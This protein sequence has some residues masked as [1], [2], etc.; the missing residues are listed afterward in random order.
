MADRG[1]W[2]LLTGA[3]AG[4]I[5]VIRIVGPGVAEFLARHFARPAK[6]GRCVHGEL[7]DRAG[8]VLDDIVVV[9]VGD[10]QTADLNLHGGP[11]VVE[12]VQNLLRESGFVAGDALDGFESSDIIEREMLAALP[13]AKTEAGIRML[14][15]QPE[16]WKKSLPDLDDLTLW[17]L[18]NP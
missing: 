4:A 5:A 14:L 3:G 7:R 6:A 17:R 8:Q 15:G 1:R 12:S 2:I 13:H 16:L 11:W 9:L 10:G 18:L